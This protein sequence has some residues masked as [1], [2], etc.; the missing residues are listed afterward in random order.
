MDET[1]GPGPANPST[2]EVAWRSRLEANRATMDSVRQETARVSG[3]IA[4][5]EREVAGTL[6]RLAAEDRRRG[7]TAAADRREARA[8][9]AERFATRESAAADCLTDRTAPHADRG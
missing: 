9:D 8:Q 2:D 3:A 6:R 5:T 7:R 1:A 4:A